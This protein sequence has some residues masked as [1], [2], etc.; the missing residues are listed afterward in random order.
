VRVGKARGR[1]RAVARTGPA[2][3][4]HGYRQTWTQFGAFVDQRAPNRISSVDVRAWLA[5]FSPATAARYLRE[6]RAGFRHAIKS[7]W[8]R[9]DPT[10]E[11]RVEVRHELGPWLPFSEWG[12]YLDACTAAHRIR[13]GFVLETGLRAGELAA[14][15]WDWIHGQVGRRALRVASDGAFVTKRDTA[16]AVPLTAAAERWLDEARAMWGG[17]GFVFSRDGLSALG[18]LARETRA[19]VAA[20]G[21]THVDFHGLRRSA[22]AAWLEHGA[23][24]LEVSRLLGHSTVRVTERWYAG[25]S[26]RH[27]GDV[28]ARVEAARLEAS[29]VPQIRSAKRSAKRS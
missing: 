18:N 15:R 12:R 26:D 4:R 17:D 10:A 25:V 14:A 22:G 6:L 28:M 7:G 29:K 5:A 13:S 3:A 19:A 27:L 11:I 20:S 8:L 1:S 9:H 23:S 16:R 21:C 2:T 24:L